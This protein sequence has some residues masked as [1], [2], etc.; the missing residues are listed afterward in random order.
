MQLNIY[1]GRNIR[2][3][4]LGNGGRSQNRTAASHRAITQSAFTEL[5]QR[6]TALPC[7]QMKGGMLSARHNHFI[8][9]KCDT[10]MHVVKYQ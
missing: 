10:T 7:L 6:G 8:R 4:K 2:N 1:V 3:V 5:Q 9:R